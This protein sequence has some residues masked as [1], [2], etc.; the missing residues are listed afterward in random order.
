MHRFFGRIH[1]GHDERNEQDQRDV[2]HGSLAARARQKCGVTA[3]EEAVHGSP[4][5]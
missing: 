4:L 5:G 1:A 2:L 3:S